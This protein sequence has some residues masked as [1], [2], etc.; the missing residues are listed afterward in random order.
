MKKIKNAKLIDLVNFKTAIIILV[1]IYSLFFIAG[2]FSAP[3]FAHFKFFEEAD[4][5]YSLFKRSCHQDA[6]R[7]F[8]VWGYQMAICARCLGVYIGTVMALGSYLISLR[9]STQSSCHAELVAA[10]HQITKWPLDFGQAF[11]SQIRLKKIFFCWIFALIGFGEICLEKMNVIDSNN[12]IRLFAGIC[13]GLF[14]GI[15]L[16]KI[17]TCCKRKGI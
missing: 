13:L 7:C 17:I 1:I 2:G 12:Y 8:W 3:I 10:S 15:I 6:L 16:V 11:L 4:S 14:I 9:N 5:I